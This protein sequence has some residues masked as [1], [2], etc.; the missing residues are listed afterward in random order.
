MLEMPRAVLGAPQL[1]SLPWWGSRAQQTSARAGAVCVPKS[2]GFVTQHKRAA[3]PPQHSP[4][5]LL[6]NQHPGKYRSCRLR[7]INYPAAFALGKFV[8]ELV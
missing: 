5:L 7:F 1:T 2:C 6:I 8:T 3:L 4:P